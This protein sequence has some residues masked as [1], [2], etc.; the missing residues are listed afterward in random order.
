MLLLLKA[1]LGYDSPLGS[2]KVEIIHAS[3]ILTSNLD[4]GIISIILYYCINYCETMG[5]KDFSVLF[6][7][8]N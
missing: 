6:V 8:Q 7:Y 1:L 3:Q 5:L 2:K 4:F